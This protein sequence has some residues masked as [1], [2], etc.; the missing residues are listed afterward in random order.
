M[1]SGDTPLLRFATDLRL[2]REQAGSPTYRQLALRAH[3]SAASL[4]VAAGG[5]RLPTLAVTAAYVEAC[6]GDIRAW[7]RRWHE[8]AAALAAEGGHRTG[9]GARPGDGHP[10]PYIGAA[11]FRPDDAEWF[12]GRD[13]LL[14]DLL[15]RLRERRVVTVT[16]PSGAGKTSLLNAGL[17]ARLRAEGRQAAI[18]GFTPGA[19]PLRELAQCLARLGA[20]P[21]RGDDEPLLVIDQFEEVFTRC[22]SRAERTHFLAMLG[23]ATTAG[24]PNHRMVICTRA[25]IHDHCLDQPLPSSALFEDPLVVGAMRPEELHRAI[26][27]PGARAGCAPDEAL[28]ARL[29]AAAAGLPGS[30]PL[31]SAVLRDAWPHRSGGTLSLAALRAAGGIED[32]LARSAEAVYTDLPEALHRR[33]GTVL[34]RLAAGDGSAEAGPHAVACT[35]LDDDVST[36]TVL[37]RFAQARVVTLDRD[38]VAWAHPAVPRAW[39]RLARWA[40]ADPEG[41]RIH[42]RLTEASRAWHANGRPPER[43]YQG[44]DLAE[45]RMLCTRERHEATARE[46]AFLS[47]STEAETARQH[48]ADA[49]RA[50]L[51]GQQHLILCLAAVV[52]VLAAALA[53]VTATAPQ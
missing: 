2:L 16:G 9:S 26:T 7:Q 27:A 3:T 17:I 21:A 13:A 12:Y 39:T 53:A 42:R 33:A 4:S 19:H 25:D 43:L 28:A 20:G 24:A 49:T 10:V 29:T 6:G 14:A 50:Y 38:R 35:D 40:E 5:R 45:A 52:A 51:R 37:E 15:E 44:A 34:L 1:D 32:R 30:L 46:R 22:R 48:T 8:V 47:A 11:P 18:V 36:R 41:L 31:L 23:S